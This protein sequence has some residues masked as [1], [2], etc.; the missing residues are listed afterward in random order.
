MY[1]LVSKSQ[2]R[3]LQKAI[4]ETEQARSLHTRA[5]V[6]HTS[7]KQNDNTTRAICQKQLE[8]DDREH[9]D[10]MQA[11]FGNIL[12][13]KNKKKNDFSF[14]KMTVTVKQAGGVYDQRLQMMLNH[15]TEIMII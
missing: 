9:L 12:Y 8:H 10:T 13:D 1:T 14:N 15:I 4:T 2:D 3:I 7:Y 11:R 6:S 5:V